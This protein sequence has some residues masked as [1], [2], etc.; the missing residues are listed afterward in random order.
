MDTLFYATSLPLPLGR[1]TAS[2]LEM[3]SKILLQK[4]VGGERGDLPQNER[5]APLPATLNSWLLAGI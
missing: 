2:L 4:K 3:S 5:V 1:A